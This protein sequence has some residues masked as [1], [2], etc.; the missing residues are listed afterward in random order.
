MC[1]GHSHHSEV[2]AHNSFTE[3]SREHLPQKNPFWTATEQYEPKEDLTVRSFYKLIYFDISKETNSWRQ[4]GAP[5]QQWTT[6]P[7]ELVARVT[8]LQKV[9]LSPVMSPYVKGIKQ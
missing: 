8:Q 9:T 7:A 5:A 3:R 2:Y 4:A 6:P 1:T